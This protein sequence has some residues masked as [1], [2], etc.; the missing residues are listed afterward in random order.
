M[1]NEICKENDTGVASDVFCVTNRK[2]CKEDFLTR[3]ERIAK[4]KPRGII[5]REKDLTREEYK[6]LAQVVMPICQKYNVPC[7]LHSFAEVALELQAEAIHLPINR[8]L[9]ISNEEKKHF[10]IIGASCHSLEEA[11]KAKD[12]GCTYIV[13][14]HIFATDCKKGLPGRGTAFLQEICESVDIPVY[15]IGGIMPENIQSIRA[16]GAAGACVMSGLMTCEEPGKYL[17]G[18]ERSR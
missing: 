5:L 1:C 16:I 17:N 18:Y 11:V 10:Q 14:G 6:A 15:G 4:A 3:I 8:L 9:G 2:L 12:A 13:A 7:I